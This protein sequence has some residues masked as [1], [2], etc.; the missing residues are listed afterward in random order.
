MNEK[1]KLL[2]FKGASEELDKTVPK[3]KIIEKALVLAGMVVNF[4][5]YLEILGLLEDFYAKFEDPDYR[6]DVELLRECVI[7]K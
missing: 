3:Q 4:A 1:R 2:D 7:S 6:R 5:K